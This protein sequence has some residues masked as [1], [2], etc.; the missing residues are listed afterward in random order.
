MVNKDKRRNLIWWFLAAIAALQLYAVRELLAVF[1]LFALGFAVVAALLSAVYLAQKG[2][3]SGVA[4]LAAS[5][6]A[7]VLGLRRYV[8]MVEDL[9]RRP[10]R[11]QHSQPV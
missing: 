6:N 5:Q 2:W 11:R 8:A 1:A 9:A 3:E 4:R 7:F 10:L